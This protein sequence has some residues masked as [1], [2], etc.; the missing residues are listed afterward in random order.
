MVTVKGFFL[1]LSLPLLSQLLPLDANGIS[2]NTTSCPVKERRALLKLKA[3]LKDPSG[4]LSSWTGRDCCEWV[5]VSCDNDMGRVVKLH[6][7]GSDICDVVDDD[8]DAPESAPEDYKPLCLSG[9]VSPSLLAL[10]H[11]TYLDLSRNNF[12]GNPIPSFL[13][14]LKRLTYLNLSQASFGGL[15]PPQLGNLSNLHYLDLTFDFY[16]RQELRVSDLNWLSGL[17]SLN[18]LNLEGV[19]LRKGSARWPEKLNMLS[20]LTELHLAGCQL[21]EFPESLSFVNFTSLSVLDLSFNKFN[22]TMPRWIFNITTLL[23]LTLIGSELKGSIP[24]VA[25]GALCGLRKIELFLNNLTGN[26]KEVAV[27]LSRCNNSSL[28]TLDLSCN[29]FNGPLP[30]SLG[31]HKY[32]RVLRLSVNSI[33]GPIPSSLGNLS[34]LVELDLS[35]NYM[36]GTIPESI[37]QLSKLTTLALAWNSWEGIVTESHLRNLKELE[38]LSLSSYRGSSLK[39]RYTRGWVPDFNLSSIEIKNCQLG[40]DFPKWLKNQKKLSS[41]TLSGA[42]IS[43]T[44]PD[45]LWELS[46]QLGILDLSQN[47]IVGK[48]PRFLDFGFEATVNLASNRLEGSFPFWLNVRDLSLKNNLVSGPIPAN[49][50]HHMS[51]LDYLDVAYNLLTGDLPS[52]VSKLKNLVYLD[53]SNNALSGDIYAGDNFSGHIPCQMCSLLPSL[54]WLKLSTN[55][56]S[57]KLPS[58]SLNCT[59]LSTLD[60]GKNRLHGLIPRWTE[61]SL[62]KLSELILQSNSF[63]GRIPEQLCNSLNLHVLDLANNNLFGSIP[64]CFG[65]MSGMKLLGMEF[66]DTPTFLTNSEVHIYYSGSLELNMKGR[67]ME[68]FELIPLVKMIDLSRNKLSGEIPPEISNLSAL[69]TLNLSNNKLM[70]SIPGKISRLKQLETLDLSFNRLSGQIPPGMS[71]MTFLNSLNLSYNNLDGEIPRGNQFTTFNP[72]SFEGNPGLCGFPLSRN[73]ST[74][75]GLDAQDQ[76]NEDKGNEEDDHG[77]LWFYTSIVLGFLVGFWSVC[78]TLVIKSSWRQAYFRFADKMKDNLYL[79]VQLKTAWLRRNW[80]NTEQNLM[81][82]FSARCFIR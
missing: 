12:Q 30:D 38:S 16:S 50:D 32:L 43:G 78:G 22:S 68:Y 14:S 53:L 35:V 44:V 61:E 23:E 81:F 40:P 3:G 17:F 26:I 51:G 55:N 1:L 33:W 28:E 64:K 39:F 48:L 21:S 65:N 69:K 41:M 34:R 42:A 59:G 6:L 80:E 31:L 18:Y 58:C 11:L 36:N 47:R 25:E 74:P 19:N 66:S 4:W 45:W 7:R 60:L 46:R 63:S 37:G 29:N 20:S 62:N 5:R 75:T 73:C 70:G 56:I 67:P 54:E 52:S 76:D 8:D 2:S 71:S 10:K 49:V 79:A 13:G 82:H 24:A 72:S 9:H 15:I 27:G 77:E 57:G